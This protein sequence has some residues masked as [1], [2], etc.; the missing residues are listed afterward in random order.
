MSALPKRK[1]TRFARDEAGDWVAQL[2]CGHTQHVRHRPPLE[3]RLWVV[4]ESGRREH[5]GIELECRSC[6]MPA[7]PE[8]LVVY[9]T[10]AWFDAETVPS[11][12]L[13]SHRLRGEVWGRI[14][15][16]SGYVVYTIE[17]EPPLVFVLSPRLQ[18][19]VQPE[20]RHHV[21]PRGNARFRVE[22]LRAEA[23]RPGVRR[24]SSSRTP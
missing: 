12:L 20:V 3:N 17:L 21:T 24:A 18:G 10:T 4:T 8:G 7:L 13:R 6:L 22:F 19:I 23:T 1:I 5:L 2:E 15:V 16:E 14:V 11:G 9:K